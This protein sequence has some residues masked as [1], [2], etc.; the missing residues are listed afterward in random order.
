M[1]LLAQ[2]R[3]CG[4]AAECLCPAITFHTSRRAAED[5]LDRRGELTGVV[6]DQA[7]ALD[8]A[9][10]SFGPL[11]S[12]DTESPAQPDERQANRW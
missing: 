8:V 3:G 7:Q 4:P 12:P 2:T 10:R 6:L 9:R 11:L 5:N 1:V